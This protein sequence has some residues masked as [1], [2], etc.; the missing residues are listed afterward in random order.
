MTLREFLTYSQRLGFRRRWA[1]T[2]LGLNLCSILFEGIGIGMFLPVLEYMNSDGDV[3]K[4]TAESRLWQGLT[5]P[6]MWQH[7]MVVGQRQPQL[8]LKPREVLGEA[9]CAPG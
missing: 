3:A 7:Q 6:A 1:A 2:I 8:S 4:L 5:E 9:I